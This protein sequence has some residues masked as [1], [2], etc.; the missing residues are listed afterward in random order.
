[1]NSVTKYDIDG[2]SLA[3]WKM[4][5]VHEDLFRTSLRHLVMQQQGL[6]NMSSLHIYSLQPI[7]HKS[8]PE[9]DCEMKLPKGLTTRNLLSMT[10]LLLN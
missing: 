6:P 2:V 9:Y 4:K 10:L 3:D 7:L 8:E 5:R 1:M